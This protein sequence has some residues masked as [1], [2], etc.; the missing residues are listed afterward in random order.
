[1][2]SRPVFGE[3]SVGIKVGWRYKRTVLYEDPHNTLA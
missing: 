1:L 3:P 2:V